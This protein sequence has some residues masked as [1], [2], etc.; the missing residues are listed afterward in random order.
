MKEQ[1]KDDSGRLT[2]R[3]TNEL[4]GD[5]QKSDLPGIGHRIDPAHNYAGH[6]DTFSRD[7]QNRLPGRSPESSTT[8]PVSESPQLDTHFLH[9]VSQ[10]AHRL[11]LQIQSQKDDLDVRERA[12]QEL[13]SAFENERLRSVQS[14]ATERSLLEALTNRL[15]ANEKAFADRYASFELQSRALEAER[16]QFS[17]QRDELELRKQSFRQEV[18]DELKTER[19]ALE[20]AKTA[21]NV[22][23][24]RVKLLETTLQKRLAELAVENDR[25]LQSEREKLWHSL[26]TEWE[27]RHVAFQQDQQA[28]QKLRDSEKAELDREKA[29][30]ESTVTSANAEFVTTR[31]ALAIELAELREQHKQQLEAEQ[32]EWKQARELEQ[33]E[34]RAARQEWEREA[35]ASREAHELALQRE[36]DAWEETRR[37]EE[38]ESIA[39]RESLDRQLIAQHE[40][41]TEAFRAERGE[42]EQAYS[43]QKEALDAQQSELL[44]ERTLIESRIRFQQDH[45]DKS[46]YEFEQVQNE[47]RHERQVER[48]RLEEAGMQIIRRLRQID[49]YRAS[50]DERE[51]S[52]DREHEVFHQMREAITST[53]E[54]DRLNI[55]AER[56]AWDQERQFQ[57]AE[58]RRQQEAVAERSESLES[59]RARLDKLRAELEETHRATLEMRLAVEEAWAQ[60]TRVTDQEDAR[61]RVEQAQK[62]LID[63]YQ[64]IHETL[65][66]QRREQIEAQTKLERQRTEFAEERQKLTHWFAARDEELRL[67]EERLRISAA[68]SS[69]QHTNWL[70]A[71]DRWLIERTEAEQ[72]IRRLL[73]SLGENNREQSRD[74]EALLP[75]SDSQINKQ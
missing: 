21:F 41:E 45:L 73:S 23:Q 6:S 46:R 68:E 65:S 53:V 40:Q 1:T 64:K 75:Q 60:V 51:K 3:P 7:Q 5:A 4:A 67:G 13:K 69:S 44:R 30:F 27:Q 20:R 14:V 66:E 12:F 42:W 72:L 38:T 2:V 31:E 35:Q 10:I 16:V 33:A 36:R 32:N 25:T 26:T 63:N 57:Q 11:H 19:E 39:S 49:Q 70:A 18:I 17:R 47:H 50:I 8:R 54:Q 62:A 15:E 59:R 58:L 52:L 24:Q 37:S 74:L 34:L 28:W 71:R 9:E 48:Q 56:Q 22:E 29:F 55:R 43:R 61:A